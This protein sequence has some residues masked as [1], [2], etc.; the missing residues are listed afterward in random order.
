MK[1]QKDLDLESLSIQKARESTRL[2]LRK[3]K[4]TQFIQDN[5]PSSLNKEIL[6]INP[7]FFDLSTIDLQ[8]ANNC[9][10]FADNL[11]FIVKSY[12][13]SNQNQ[14]RYAI[15]KTRVFLFS[16]QGPKTSIEVE[17]LTGQIYELIKILEFYSDKDAAISFEL[18]SIFSIIHY[19]L[20]NETYSKILFSDQY[21]NSV[22]K[23]IRANG[24]CS[25]VVI[26][27]LIAIGN[28]VTNPSSRSVLL[29][30]NFFEYLVELIGSFRSIE[31]LTSCVWIFFLIV[32][33]KPDLSQDVSVS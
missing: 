29:L 13:I 26:Y 14:L 5:K 2:E 1:S 28:G 20:N 22:L 25:E 16:D 31:E 21:V 30:S 11:N 3:Q 27:S 12:T 6:T 7:A 8:C 9:R 10:C 23:F 17:E 15:Y 18:I 33:I 19:H 32:S 4:I 24:D